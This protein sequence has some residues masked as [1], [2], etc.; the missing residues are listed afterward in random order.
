[1]GKKSNSN[2]IR[3]R[4]EDKEKFLTLKREISEIQNM[5][6]SETELMRR[7]LN[8]PNLPK[9]LKEDA[10]MKRKMLALD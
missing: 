6:I 2:H 3:I 1:M 5:K 10:K 8:I 4:Y 7:T 9:V